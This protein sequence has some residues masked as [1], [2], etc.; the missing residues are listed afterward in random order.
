[1]A[2]PHAR[3]VNPNDDYDRWL[4]GLVAGSRFGPGDRLGT[5]NHIDAAARLRAAAAIVT[6]DCVPLAR[7]IVEGAGDEAGASISVDCSLVQLPDFNGRPWGSGGMPLDAAGDVT[8][9]SAH[10][11]TNTHLDALNHMGRGGRW[12]SGFAVDDPDGHSLVPLADH[13]LFT[14]GVLVDVPAVRGTDWVD[15]EQPVTGEDLDAA[16]AATGTVFEPGDALLLYM[17]RDRYEAAGREMQIGGRQPTPGAGAGVARWIVEHRASML[18]WDFLDA[19]WPEQPDFPVHLLIWAIGLLLVDNAHLGGAAE[20]VRRTGRATGA[21]VV[22][23][24]AIPRATGALVQP[25]FL[26]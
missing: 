6:G 7:P 2:D 11:R 20:Q 10:G 26:Q 4:T 23:P 24:P 3:V 25:L 12:Y 21:F 16:L 17:G 19:M 14:R 13:G 18:C 1:M 9:V 22:T 8:H 5:A 15:S